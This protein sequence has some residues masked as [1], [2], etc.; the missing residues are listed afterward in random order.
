MKNIIETAIDN[1]NFTTL[2]KALTAA[3]LVETLEGTGPFTVFA[4]TDAAFDKIPSET[5]DVVLKDNEKLTSI[6]TYHVLSGKTLSKNIVNMS[7][8]KTLNGKDVK[9]DS[10]R[11]VKV[12]NSNV[13]TADVECSN[14]VIHV[15]D[16]VLM[17]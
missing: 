14:G 11:G 2:V 13:T 10:E 3:N 4:P 1:G 17:P 16:T 8:A 7:T 9:I 12:N 6:L 5:M 15:I